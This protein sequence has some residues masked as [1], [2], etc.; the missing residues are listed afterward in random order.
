MVLAELAWGGYDPIEWTSSTVGF[1]CYVAIV[2]ALLGYLC[3]QQAV[4]RTGSQLPMFFLNSRRSL[5]Q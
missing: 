2:P 5:P 1:V 3:W 4:A